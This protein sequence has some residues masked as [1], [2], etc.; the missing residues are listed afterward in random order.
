M[1]FISGMI[2]TGFLV[3]GLFFLKF[4]FRSRDVLFFIFAVAFWLFAAN[5]VLL[6][7][8]DLPREEQGW[9]YLLRLAAFALIVIAIAQK[10]L[11]RRV[12]R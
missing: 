3:A 7:I 10:N 11:A 6:V 8:L 2:T 1:N 4:W 12:G 5:Q 9:V